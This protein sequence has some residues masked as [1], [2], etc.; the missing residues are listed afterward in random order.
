MTRKTQIRPAINIDRIETRAKMPAAVW[1]AVA[2]AEAGDL[3]IANVLVTDG[4]SHLWVFSPRKYNL[5]M[6]YVD[7][8]EKALA[9]MK[10]AG[11]A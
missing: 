1:Q 4:E 10:E 8:L 9:D 3:D 7:G 5:L 11:N 2:R 6:D